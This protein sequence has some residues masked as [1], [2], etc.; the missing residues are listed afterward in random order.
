[1]PLLI[2][3]QGEESGSNLAILRLVRCPEIELV[4]IHFSTDG[5]GQYL[6][7]MAEVGPFLCWFH[8]LSSSPRIRKEALILWEIDARNI[9]RKN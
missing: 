8:V 6:F 9:S 7:G 5:Q 2:S 3:G 4:G 1:M